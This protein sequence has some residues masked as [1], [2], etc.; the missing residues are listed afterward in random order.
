MFQILKGVK[1]NRHLV[2][3]ISQIV[4]KLELRNLAADEDTSLP[5][6]D[7]SQMAQNQIEEMIDG[8]LRVLN[9]DLLQ[10]ADF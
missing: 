8:V 9:L 7:M 6:Q 2:M 5:T 1:D 4:T 10:V 3:L